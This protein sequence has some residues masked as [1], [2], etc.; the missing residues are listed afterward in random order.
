MAEGRRGG[1]R[2]GGDDDPIGSELAAGCGDG[3]HAGEA[4]LA[5]HD[6]DTGIVHPALIAAI[7]FT[8]V[9]IHAV[10]D[11]LCVDGAEICIDEVPCGITDMPGGVGESDEE[12]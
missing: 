9:F 6:V 11:P 1:A 2:A 8:D 7:D 12:L 3:L 4:A 5:A 10:E